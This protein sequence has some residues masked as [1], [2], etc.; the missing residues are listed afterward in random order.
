ME[1]TM[2]K[3]RRSSSLQANSI[4]N[5]KLRK[6]INLI[7]GLECRVMLA[8]QP[9]LALLSPP[10][11]SQSVQGQA[12]SLTATITPFSA[13]ST[14]TGNVTFVVNGGTKTFGP[15]ALDSSGNA[16]LTTAKL[17]VGTDSI[18]AKYGGDSNYLPATSAPETETVSNGANP[19]VTTI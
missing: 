9:A 13:G 5:R 18:V 7:E 10:T 8:A 16:S 3:A 11:P 17:P 4:S 19:S 12:V 1:R 15:I 2:G 6:R 14:P